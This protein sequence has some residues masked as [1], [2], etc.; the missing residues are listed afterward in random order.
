RGGQRAGHPVTNRRGDAGPVGRSPETPRAGGEGNPEISGTRAGSHSEGGARQG[1][2][3]SA[4]P[5]D[6]RPAED[7]DAARSARQADRLR[8][9][10]GAD[11]GVSAGKYADNLPEL[12][13]QSCLRGRVWASLSPITLC[14]K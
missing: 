10:P 1:P 13:C 5:G 9:S 12:I 3:I 4:S 14:G 11:R 7:P 6:P 8:P 2:A